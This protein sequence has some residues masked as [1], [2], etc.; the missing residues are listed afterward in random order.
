M[1][2]VDAATSF[3]GGVA[4]NGA[5]GECGT[6][7]LKAYSSADPSGIARKCAVRYFADCVRPRAHSASPTNGC[8]FCKD[9][10]RDLRSA[11]G[12]TDSSGVFC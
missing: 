12:T 2:A 4:R 3:F 7:V 6:G 8:I 9:A 11:G 5:I 10:V 1:I